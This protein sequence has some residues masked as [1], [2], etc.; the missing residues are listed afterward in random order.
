MVGF[1]WG[2]SSSLQTAPRIELALWSL[3]IK[4]STCSWGSTFMTW[5]PPKGPASKYH[6]IGDWISVFEF[7]GE[8]KIQSKTYKCLY[9]WIHLEVSL[10][11]SENQNSFAS[12]PCI[13]LILE[14]P[15]L[16]CLFNGYLSPSSLLLLLGSPMEHFSRG[17]HV[18]PAMEQMERR[19][20]VLWG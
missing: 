9:S 13:L 2:S 1:W 3:P 7:G 16:T 10:I 5:L 4:A 18:W 6:D 11:I 17:P 12:P 14:S 19:D 15:C 8:T 20:S